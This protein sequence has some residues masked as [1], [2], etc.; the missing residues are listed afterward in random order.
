MPQDAWAWWHQNG[1]E[2]QGGHQ[3]KTGGNLPTDT[4]ALKWVLGPVNW[5]PAV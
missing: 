1:F 5:N 3:Q 4:K 2:S